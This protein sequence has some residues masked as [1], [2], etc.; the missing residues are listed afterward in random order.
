M[1]SKIDDN[2]RHN[3]ARKTSSGSELPILAGK[4]E[5]WPVFFE[6]FR[7]SIEDCGFSNAENMGRLRKCLKGKA[8]ETVAAMLAVPDNLTRVMAC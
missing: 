3:M 5:E 7:S 4:P 6:Q 2:M 1:G 8:I